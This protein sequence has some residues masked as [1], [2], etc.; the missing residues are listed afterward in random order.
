VLI[1]LVF[2]AL[3][4][5]PGAGAAAGFVVG[6]L[7]DAVAPTA[8]GAAALAGTTV[9]YAAA[10]LRALTFT[11]NPLVTALFVFAAAWL[12]DAIQ[13]LASNQL[14]GG[15]LL[16]QLGAL[17]PLAGLTTAGAAF[18]VLVVFR[19]WLAARPA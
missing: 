15:A 7:T 8:F 18:A 5:R 17:S 10:W 1:A 19:G 4:T 12:R 13:V 14:G 16:W 11:D 2:F 3:R 9:G 6:L